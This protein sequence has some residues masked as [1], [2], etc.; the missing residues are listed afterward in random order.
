MLDILMPDNSQAFAVARAYRQRGK[1]GYYSFPFIPVALASFPSIFLS[2]P[3][4]E[5]H[6]VVH[7]TIM[8]PQLAWIGLGNMGRVRYECG[9]FLQ[10][11]VLAEFGFRACAK[12]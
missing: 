8:A 9:C 5:H 12:T 6:K 2:N 1:R 10:L 3:P 7:R 11:R 4:D